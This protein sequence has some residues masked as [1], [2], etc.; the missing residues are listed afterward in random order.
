M[1]KNKGHSC[2]AA[3]VRYSARAVFCLSACASR[4]CASEPVLQD[5]DAFDA[6]VAARYGSLGTE[7]PLYPPARLS[8]MLCEAPHPFDP[9]GF[10]GLTNAVSPYLVSGGVPAWRL[11]VIETQ[12]TFRAWVAYAGNLAVHTNAVPSSFDTTQWVEE[13]F[14]DH[15][16]WLSGAA[17]ELWYLERERKRIVAQYALIPSDRYAEYQAA[18]TAAYTNTS[19]SS[20]DPVVPADTNRV[21]FA[22]V[23]GHNPT[24]FDLDLYVP[25][26]LPVD[27]FRRETLAGGGL[28]DYVGTVRTTHPFTPVLL[29][30]YGETLFLH[31]ARADV[32]TDGDGIPDGLETLSLGTDPGLW[33]TDGD[34]L[35]DRSEVFGYGTNPNLVDTDNDGLTDGEEIDGGLDPNRLTTMV[36]VENLGLRVTL[37]GRR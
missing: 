25:E 1:M 31:A 21:A 18:L 8:F 4:V 32:D 15:P 16:A 3:L 22:R 6:I 28:W 11:R 26:T 24:L 23:A 19:L 20:A 35:A 9:D 17:L 13:A 29:P 12:L 33:D 10:D 2:C 36:D 5:W 14:G 37:P 34:G 27:L 7:T 30:R